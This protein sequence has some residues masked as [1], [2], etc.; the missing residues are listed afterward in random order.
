MNN[1][2]NLDF[3]D[4]GKQSNMNEPIPRGTYKLKIY[5]RQGGAGSEGVLR[6][7]KNGLSEM[8]DFEFTVQAGSYAARKLW[9]LW[10]FQ[11]TAENDQPDQGL[12]T[13]IEITRARIKALLNSARGVDPE[14][15]SDEA[16][17]KQR[18][19]GL[20][21]LDGLIFVARVGIKQ[22]AGYRDK[23]VIDEIIQPDDKLWG[24]HMQQDGIRAAGTEGQAQ[25]ARKKTDPFDDEIPF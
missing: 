15:K 9:E 21:D 8:L 23:N 18:L 16:R 17:A 25:I 14:D 12:I 13:A 24:Q 2:N 5:M 22:Q 4:A 1:G 6:T 19:N 10:V 3:S 11:T 20:L 7:S